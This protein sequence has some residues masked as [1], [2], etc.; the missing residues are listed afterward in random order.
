[1]DDLPEELLL[2]IFYKLDIKA[3]GSC[4]C[5]K[6]SWLSLIKNP[7]FVSSYT[8]DDKKSSEYL[9]FRQGNRDLQCFV[10]KDHSLHL[11]KVLTSPFELKKINIPRYTVSCCNGVIC[12]ANTYVDG[13]ILWNPTIQKFFTLPKPNL[14]HDYNNEV[15]EYELVFGFGFDSILNDYKVVRIIIDAEESAYRAEIFSLNNNSWKSIPS[16][17]EIVSGGY[18]IICNNALPSFNGALHWIGEH[19]DNWEDLVILCFNVNK[20]VFHEIKLPNNLHIHTPELLVFE[21]YSII[22]LFCF[23]LDHADEDFSFEVWA[24]KEYGNMESWTRMW[25]CHLPEFGSGDVF[26]VRDNG[27]LLCHLYSLSVI[28]SLDPMTG[29]EKELLKAPGSGFDGIRY[30]ESLVLLDDPKALSYST[31][32]HNDN[33]MELHESCEN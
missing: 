23:T 13:T 14:T 20:E 8:F 6:K 4:V 16:H 3:I 12:I 18:R 5:V 30:R 31:T 28:I 2:N 24:M 17:S 11:H 32:Q 19:I 9:I 29:K 1:M 33:F 7:S 22:S 26:G 25:K 15:Y 10:D 21:Q 27:E